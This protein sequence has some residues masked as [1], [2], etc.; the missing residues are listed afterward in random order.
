MDVAAWKLVLRDMPAASSHCH[1]GTPDRHV[2]LNLRRLLES[3]YAAANED[4]EHHFR[5]LTDH[6]GFSFAVQDSY[7]SPGSDLGR[8]ELFRPTYRINHWVM[9]HRPGAADHNGNSPWSLP[10]F[11]PASPEE[12]LA[13]M[14][15]QVEAAV[16]GGSVA[17]KSALAYDR[18]VS[19]DNPDWDAARRAF[20]CQE[21][22]EHDR[23]AFGDVVM[24]RICDVAA[25]LGVPLQV[26]LGLGTISGSRPMLF[27]PTVAAHPGTIFDLFHGGYPWCSEIGGLLHNYGNV[28]AD[29]C[30]LPLI[31]TTAAVR[32]LHEYLDVAQSAD[33]IVWGDD[34]WTGEE[35]Y[36]A[37]LAW[38]HVLAKVLA[39]RTADG[40]CS[41]KQAEAL[42][43]KLMY[44]NAEKLFTRR[45][46]TP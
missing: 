21:S 2:D 37:R 20:R 19:F 8:P 42:A 13:L 31:S 17:L 4:P 16:A 24:H 22:A 29:L 38:E 26:H 32:A 11:E 1:H 36:G 46:G 9:A 28:I 41:P 14:E 44:R 40:L 35:A 30:W 23:R 12:Y 15:A 39:E 18:P 33:R 27:E 34:T 43:E 5:L 45:S 25:R 3:S 6:A 7:W 10:G